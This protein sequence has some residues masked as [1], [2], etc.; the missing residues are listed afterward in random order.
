MIKDE[1]SKNA[2]L[3]TG[4]IV[5][6]SGKTAVL[7]DGCGRMARRATRVEPVERRATTTAGPVV[8]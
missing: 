4:K 6:N 7:D 2:T 8:Y 5:K 1:D 3:K